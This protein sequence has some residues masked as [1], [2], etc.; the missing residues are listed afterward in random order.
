MLVLVTLHQTGS[1]YD[2]GL[3]TGP[4]FFLGRRKFISFNEI[5]IEDLH[6][7]WC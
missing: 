3:L 1:L 7:S 2:S 5:L 4:Y 6:R